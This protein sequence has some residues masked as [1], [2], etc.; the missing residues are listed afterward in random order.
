MDAPGDGEDYNQD[1][2]PIDEAR[3]LTDPHNDETKQMIG[4][5]NE[6]IREAASEGKTQAWWDVKNYIEKECQ[7]T[8]AALHAFGRAGYDTRT[9]WNGMLT[10]CY[11]SWGPE[12][13]LTVRFD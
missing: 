2:L 10:R 11:V 4:K 12:G 13:S 9:E 6:L 7:R 5:I 1:P 8:L 3:R